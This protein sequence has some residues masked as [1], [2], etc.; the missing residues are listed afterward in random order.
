MVSVNELRYQ[1]A[2]QRMKEKAAR[3]W[4]RYVEVILN[5]YGVKISDYR[6]QR[7]EYLGRQRIP[8]TYQQVAQTFGQTDN[9]LIH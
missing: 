7:S 5:Q 1:F 6:V 8:I 9:P 4:T 3:G 2:I